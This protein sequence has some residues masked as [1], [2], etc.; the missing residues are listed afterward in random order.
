MAPN[1][2]PATVAAVLYDLRFS[3]RLTLPFAALIAVSFLVTSNVPGWVLWA[4]FVLGWIFQLV[5]HYVYE[6]KTPA[7]LENLRQ[8]LV[9]PLW[10]ISEALPKRLAARDT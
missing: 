9:G 5:G 10:L 7:F 3:V 2:V 8:L 4:G 1:A 6:K